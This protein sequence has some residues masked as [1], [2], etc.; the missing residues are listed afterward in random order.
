MKRL[1]HEKVV[2]ATIRFW[3]YF[4]ILCI[5]TYLPVY[6]FFK[7]SGWQNENIAR[8]ITAYK[9][10]Q[11]KHRVLKEKTDS[12]FNQL[13][14]LNSG[15]VEND[16]FLEK[17]IAD[18]KNDIVKTIGADSATEFKHYALLMSNVESMLKQKDTILSITNKEH[19][20]FS[21]LQ[22]CMNKTRKIK[23]DL[24]YDPTRNFS[25]KK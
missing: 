16:L 18:N 14:L 8:D 5:F 22:E 19:L 13:S 24:S 23:L 17:Y 20:A 25:T 2:Q 7:C 3:I 12:L 10:I 9:E 11:N 1:N 4:V 6:F 15:K 21:D